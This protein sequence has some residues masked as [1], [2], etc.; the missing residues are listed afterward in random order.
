[1][2]G[3]RDSG[4]GIRNAETKGDNESRSPN[5]ESRHDWGDMA[6]VGRIAR[7]HGL[8][9]EVVINPETDFVEER[10]A[11]GA[12]VWARSA[13][14]DE[15][16]T[17]GSMR[18]QN[19]RPVVGFEGFT[20]VEDVERLAGVELRV[21]EETLQPLQA[22]TYYEHQLVGCIVETVAG[23]AVGKVA[24]VEGGAGATRLVM[25]GPRGEILIPLAVDICVEIDVANKRIQINPPE[26]LLELN[27]RGPAKAG[28][29]G[30]QSVRRGRL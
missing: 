26:G 23:D 27:E 21:P 3:I 20:R 11:E 30:V 7:P 4:L 24:A 14:G 16:L 12:I 13:A 6:L 25:N 29:Y 19:G 2:D 28:P 15:R 5:P 9:G 22:G 18:V 17:V 1:M 10:F 8:R